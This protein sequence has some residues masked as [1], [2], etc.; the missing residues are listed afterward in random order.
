MKA[1]PLGPGAGEVSVVSYGAWPLSERGRPGEAES[2]RVIQAALDGGATLIDTAD[3]YCQHQGEAGHNERLVAQALAGWSGPRDT[4]TVATKGGF[5]RPDGDWQHNGRPDHLRQACDRSLLALG[6]DRIDLYQ[7]H[8]PDPDVPLPESVGLLG[9]LQQEGKIRW[10]GLSNV[11]VDELRLAQTLVD[12]TTVQNR[13]NP[14]FRE[15]VVDGG[16]GGVVAEC[17]DQGLGFLAYSPVGGGRLNKKLPDHPVLGPIAERHG[18]S[19]HAV[20]LA[21][22]LAQG[23]TV[24]VIPAARQMAHVADSQA[25]AEIELSTE[26][27][28]EIDEAEFSVA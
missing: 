27:L 2:I 11:T 16:R 15:A 26:E 14:F 12:V 21:W 19:P 9:E 13:L 20:A 24:I 5:V 6:V 3:A 17:A 18:V 8:S 22:D 7:L 23:P 1:R 28:A 10:V 25:A 4:I